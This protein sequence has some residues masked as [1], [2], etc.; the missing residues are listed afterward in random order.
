M[1]SIIKA[2]E[3]ILKQA[4]LTT[5]IMGIA[6]ILGG[7][8]LVYLGATGNTEFTLFDNQFKST[9]VGAVGIFCGAV[10]VILGQRRSLK[11]LD[12]IGEQNGDHPAQR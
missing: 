10:V 4:M 11:S 9:S 6:L 12:R 2:S 8:A 3:G 7:I 5:F 1:A